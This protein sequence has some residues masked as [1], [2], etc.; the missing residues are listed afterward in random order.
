[1]SHSGQAW[2]P[3][4][5][6][7]QVMTPPLSH[8]PKH[9]IVI[10]LRPQGQRVWQALT[11][12]RVPG[13]QGIGWL[14]EH[15]DVMVYVARA[16]WPEVLGRPR[17]CEHGERSP[18]PGPARSEAGKALNTVCL[19][20]LQGLPWWSSGQD[21]ARPVQGAWVQSLVRELDPA[22]G[23]HEFTCND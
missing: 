17:T 3:R 10:I 7:L 2:A 21:S 8:R 19:R 22:Y 12:L 14:L 4:G 13:M 15:G 9:P 5:L 20:P 6:W 23:N 16:G 11:L 1:M 18:Q